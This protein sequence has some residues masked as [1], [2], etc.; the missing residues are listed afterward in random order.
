MTFPLP[1]LRGE[2]VRALEELARIIRRGGLPRNASPLHIQRL[3]PAVGEPA[4]EELAGLLRSGLGTSHA[5][6]LL[7]VIVAERGTRRPGDG[8]E[9]VTSGPDATGA[10]RDTGVVMRELFTAAEERVLVVGFAVHQGRWVF[11]ALAE[12]LDERPQLS[13]RLCLAVARR[14]GDSSK[15]SGIMERFATRLREQEWPGSRLPDA[16][17]DPRALLEGEAGRASLHAKCVVVDGSAAL[18]GSAN[19]TEAAQ[20][21]N[22]EVGLLAHS[23]AIA[24]SIE[25]HFDGLIRRGLLKALPWR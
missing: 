4:A 7:E 18:V 1:A 6:L 22:I 10:T 12:R 16:F 21:R 5:A 11:R 25:A 24:Q 2:G 9:I 23:T 20:Q 17:Y 15:S 13:V 19:F 8:L 3:L 14:P